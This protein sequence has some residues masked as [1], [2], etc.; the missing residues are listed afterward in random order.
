MLLLFNKYN[1]GTKL[2]KINEHTVY[3]KKRKRKK[4]IRKKKREIVKKCKYC[5]SEIDEE[6]IVCPV[7]K[8]NQNQR[9]NINMII[10]IIG[11]IFILFMILLVGKDVDET[12]ENLDNIRDNAVEQRDNWLNP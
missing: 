5:K 11:I 6:A 9:R 12:E 4:I 1:M 7:C 3:F 2:A 8:R 10:I